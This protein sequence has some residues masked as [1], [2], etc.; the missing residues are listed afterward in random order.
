MNDTDQHTC[1]FR[2]QLQWSEWQPERGFRERLRYS[3]PLCIECGREQPARRVRPPDR[4][5]REA[6]LGGAPPTRGEGAA[7]IAEVLARQS[8]DE[9]SFKGIAGALRMPA[10]LI[11]DELEH[12]LHAGWIALVWKID[13][14]R[15]TLHRIRICNRAG[16]EEF[17]H[18]GLSA[19]RRAALDSARESLSTLTHP[20]AADV[21]RLLEQ[22][23]AEKWDAQVVRGLA[24]IASHAETGDQLAE[25]VFSTHYLGSS[26]AFHRVRASV[27]RLL[28]QPVEKLGIREGAAAVFIG[29]R[30]RLR[31]NDQEID[32]V[33]LYPFAGF[34]RETLMGKIALQPPADGL[35]LVENFTVFEA[36]CQREVAGTEDTMVV[37]TAGYPGRGVRSLVEHATR[38]RAKVRI[39]ADLDLDGV[40]IARLV[41]AWAAGGVEAFKMSPRDLTTAPR[42]TKLEDRARKA[43]RAELTEQPEAFL[44]DTLRAVLASDFWVEQECFLALG[45]ASK[46]PT[47]AG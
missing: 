5:E 9:R 22:P 43:I 41:R 45:V 11:E 34:A 19:E 4:L 40:R 33:A 3:I 18:P 47:A 23:E 44:S 21:A 46:L 26:K 35:L 10:S 20:V 25:R 30:G 1:R 42:S 14:A 39:W 38:L 15:K 31:I 17:A 7:K 2:L 37:W 24:A 28:G 32:L 29:G 8:T 27:E 16:L 6:R 12:L 13:G 36:C